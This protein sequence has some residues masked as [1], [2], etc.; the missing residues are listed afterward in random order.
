MKILKITFIVLI[1]IYSN[2]VSSQEITESLNDDNKAKKQLIE[3]K[4]IRLAVENQYIRGLQIRDFEL[5][6]AICIPETKL[7]GINQNEQLNV[8]SLDKWSKRFDPQNPPFKN[9]DFSIL[10]I[11]REGNS[12][13]VK[14]LFLVDS[15]NYITDFLHMLKI[16]G[17]WKIVNII[18]Y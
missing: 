5:I 2:S 3:E 1:V 18:D 15:K 12:A 16:E 8:T 10:K 11:D 6:R 7:M 4:D 17:K 9:L 13:Q 14:I